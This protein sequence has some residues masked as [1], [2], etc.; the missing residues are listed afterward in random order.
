MFGESTYTIEGMKYS[1]STMFWKIC[2]HYVNFEDK[3]ISRE[4]ERVKF[5]ERERVK[6]DTESKKTR[7]V[8]RLKTQQ[9][10]L[11]SKSAIFVAIKISIEI[12]QADARV[13][14]APLIAKAT[15]RDTS[16]AARMLSAEYLRERGLWKQENINQLEE[17]I[18]A[19]VT[20]RQSC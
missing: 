10:M 16:H 6:E 7:G 15:W 3:T 14:S 13:S 2:R 17:W 20:S 1:W 18:R 8:L 9:E 11:S 4:M 19:T 5:R 12:L